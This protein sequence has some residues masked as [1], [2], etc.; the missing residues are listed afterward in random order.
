MKK[1]SLIQA[2]LAFV[3]LPLITVAQVL[4]ADINQN[5]ESASP[6]NIYA[7][8]GGVFF[9]ARHP[10]YGSE[11]FSTNATN[12]AV[13]LLSDFTE[14]GGF[15]SFYGVNVIDDAAYSITYDVNEAEVSIWKIDLNTQETTLLLSFLS[16]GIG[17]SSNGAFTK[18]GELIFFYIRDVNY[19][20]Q[21][22]KTGGTPEST[23][24]VASLPPNSFP[25]EFTAANGK[26]FF[27]TQAAGFDRILWVS[28]G[29]FGGTFILKDIDPTIQSNGAHYLTSFQDQLWFNAND[30]ENGYE[31]WT[32]DGTL[33]GTKIFLDIWPGTS[34]SFP[35]SLQLVGDQLFFS[36]AAEATGSELW[37]TDGTEAGTRLVKDV[38]TGTAQSFLRSFYNGGDKLYF[39]ATDGAHGRELWTSDGTESGTYQV[40]DIWTGPGDA[41]ESQMTGR[42]NNGVF[43][44]VAS[45]SLHGPELWRTDGTETVLVKDIYAGSESSAISRM[46]VFNGRL[47]FAAEDLEHGSE[48]WVSDG[49]TSGTQLYVDLNTSGASSFANGFIPFR[50]Q[51]IFR[52][53]TGCLGYEPWITDGTPTGTRLIKD[54]YPGKEQSGLLSTVVVNDHFY[55]LAENPDY[56]WEVWKSDGT[57][58]GTRILR[59]IGEGQRGSSTERIKRLRNNILFSAFTPEVGEEIWIS[60]GTTEGT[61]LLKDIHPTSQSLPFFSGEASVLGDSILL[62]SADDGV[63]G[64][65]LW[66]TNGTEDGTQMVKEINNFN[67]G[68]VLSPIS[69]LKVVGDIAYFAGDNGFSGPELWRTDGTEAGTYRIKEIWP[70]NTGSDPTRFTL[71]KGEVYFTARSFEYGRELWKTDGTESGT[72]LVRDIQPG[73]EGS[74]PYNYHVHGDYLY[75]V[76]D[77]DGQHGTE[78]WRTDGTTEGTQMVKDIRPGPDNSYV[79]DLISFD[80]LL[81]FSADDGVNGREL[82]STDGTEAGTRMVFDLFPGVGSGDPGSFIVYKDFL[83]FSATEGTHGVELWKYSPYDRDNDGYLPADDPDDNDPNVNPGII[84]PIAIGEGAACPEET[85]NSVWEIRPES[86]K[87]YPN[88]TSSWLDIEFSETGT[89]QLRLLGMDG[90]VWMQRPFSSSVTLDVS[91]LAGGMYFL[92]IADPTQKGRLVKKVQIVR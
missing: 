51:L 49:T 72:V 50:E 75:F 54:I 29:T 61:R 86:L 11:L 89:Y 88:P 45:D 14:P 41:F 53:Q 74:T 22:W 47:F 30:A 79:R 68:G 13:D 80:T 42:A 73:I 25:D 55:V 91:H 76:V 81:Y 28:D 26:L 52:A 35:A 44:F 24:F 10:E 38:A 65:E 1:L 62:F 70:G 7:W 40:K 4:V 36:A 43:Y 48:L 5:N 19:N 3:C 83:Y 17:S 58:A 82:W 9:S 12:S 46:T 33:E 71:F 63:R 92:E 34:S 84:D 69:S 16:Q 2:A 60:D 39:T 56:G 59:D 67:T 78:L 27:T 8:S 23:E 57:E 20:F 15:N 21:L 37:A 64:E 87:L 90:R 32:S 77:T 66:K 85:P 6:E 18:V 31:L